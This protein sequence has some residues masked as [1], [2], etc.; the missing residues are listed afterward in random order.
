MVH[1]VKRERQT[2]D[3]KRTMLALERSSCRT[4][5]KS[6]PAI[7]R[8]AP[9]RSPTP[10]KSLAMLEFPFCRRTRATSIWGTE[11][12][13][14]GSWKGI[15][16]ERTG[17]A[18]YRDNAMREAIP[19]LATSRAIVQDLTMRVSFGKGRVIYKK[20]LRVE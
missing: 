9:T 6:M 7:W 11:E 17:I 12:F 1:A 2:E 10:Y 15:G 18:R 20:D 19:S 5:N 3:D 4:Q 14:V 16:K 13:G 8:Y